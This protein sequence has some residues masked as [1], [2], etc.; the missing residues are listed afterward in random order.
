MDEGTHAFRN[1]GRFLVAALLCTSIPSRRSR[2]A[3]QTIALPSL[4]SC[5]S[6]DTGVAGC[7][8]IAQRSSQ[9]F[10]LCAFASDATGQ[11]GSRKPRRRE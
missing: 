3:E 4:A 7:S 2:A 8:A 9:E 6:V 1:F 5:L 11:S 10:D